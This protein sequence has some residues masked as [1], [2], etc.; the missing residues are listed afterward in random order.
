MSPLKLLQEI[1]HPN[2]WKIMICCICLNLTQGV[3]VHQVIKQL[4]KKYPNAKAMANARPTELKRIIKSLGL[5]N[6]RTDT[7][8]KFSQEWLWKEWEQ[9]R[10]LHGIG[11]YAQDSFSIFAE[12]L[13]IQP[14]D[15]ELK[16][17]VKW[18]YS[19]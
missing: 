6:K 10:E 19:T 7:L 12:G 18:K 8:M 2:E 15:K 17:Y 9:P 1:Y 16:K 5:Y 4:F 13:H 3:Q 14:Q 11:Q